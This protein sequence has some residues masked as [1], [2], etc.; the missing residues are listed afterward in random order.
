M[1]A[2][3]LGLFVIL[4]VHAPEAS[5]RSFVGARATHLGFYLLAVVTGVAANLPVG[6]LHD[7]IVKR[8]P[9]PEG[10]DELITQFTQAPA[11]MKVAL[12]VAVV[13]IGP[14]LEEL[15]FRGAIF[16]PLLRERGHLA[17]ILITAFFF[18]LVH[19]IPQ[20]LPPLFLMGGLLGYF[21]AASG[22]LGPAVAM[23]ASFNAVPFAAML[24]GGDPA[25]DEGPLPLGWALGGT[26]ACVLA[27]GS[28]HV[29]ARGE[30]AA[31]ARAR[32]G[33]GADAP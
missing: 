7:L 6:W 26:A 16:G 31:K 5:I 11:A 17:V 2:Y 33:V 23:H 8:W 3:A 29:L 27:V 12:V 9:E 25:A 18:A 4:R 1:A 22:S 30:R 28:A 15:F 13:L 21:R 20:R 32:D 24:A 10:L 19:Q 14:F